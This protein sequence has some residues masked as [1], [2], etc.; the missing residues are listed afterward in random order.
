MRR[1]GILALALDGGKLI[2]DRTLRP[3]C[4]SLTCSLHGQ[5]VLNGDGRAA[6]AL[7]LSLP[8]LPERACYDVDFNCILPS[9]STGKK[10]NPGLKIPKEAFE[11]P[12]TSST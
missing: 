10:R 4:L 2:P 12:Q 11:Q 8:S 9:F 5:D 3:G 7:F 6:P 1:A